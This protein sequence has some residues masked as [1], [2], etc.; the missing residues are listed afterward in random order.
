MGVS[1]AASPSPQ[2]TAPVDI[3]ALPVSTAEQD[4]AVET[5]V[6]NPLGVCD[7]DPAALTALVANQHQYMHAL[8]VSPLALRARVHAPVYFS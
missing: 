8:H 5:W 4:S 3:I 1:K 2:H 7:A 6:A